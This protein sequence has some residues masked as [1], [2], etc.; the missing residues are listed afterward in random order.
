MPHD[1]LRYL[2]ERNSHYMLE[3]AS[4]ASVESCT[5]DREGLQTF[6]ALFANRLRAL[7]LEVEPLGPG[8][9][10]L[11]GRWRT[12]EGAPLL[13][14]G[15]GD[16]VYPR[17]TLS[18]QPVEERD[19]RLFGPGVYDMKGGL[20]AMCAAIEALQAHGRTPRRP[21][22]LLMTDDE[23][24]GSPA[25][26]PFIE[27]V[28]REAEAVLV[29]EPAT[30]A[31]ALKTARKGVA[32]FEL[33]V[34][35]RAAHAGV[36]P[37]QGRSAL[38]ELAH[39]ILWLSGLN[40]P[41]QGTTLNVGIAHGGTA[42]NVVPASAIAKID[43]RVTTRAEADR[44]TTLLAERAA[45]TPD[46]GV[47]YTGGLR[48]PPME[49]TAANTALFRQ[50]HVLARELGFEVEEGSSGGA[51]DGNFTAALGIP[52]LDGLGPLGDGAHAVHEH[53]VVDEFP[54]RAALL[55]RLLETLA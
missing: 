44:I 5:D 51:S 47:H 33:E 4:W 3:L 8:G 31:G 28:A 18:R 12:G 45:V 26:R 7:N 10:R 43:V 53:I 24:T 38:V 30:P 1:I 35:G 19:G 39:Q 21:I 29:L 25:S 50:A 48:N 42:F 9:A 54:R 36:A 22:F 34:T 32:T 20:M 15:H 6:S 11:L 16:T 14:V 13:L 55:A 46:V 17:G 37:H 2:Q 49:R 52:T 41:E 23:E 40:A 27:Q